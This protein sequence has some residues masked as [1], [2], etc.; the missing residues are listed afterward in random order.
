MPEKTQTERITL[1]DL[2]K[3][4]GKLKGE[5]RAWKDNV[6][7]SG[8]LPLLIAMA[9]LLALVVL[10]CP[11]CLVGV[12]AIGTA[13]AF[14]AP[15]CIV[16]TLI[17]IVITTV[18]LKASNLLK[19]KGVALRYQATSITFVLFGVVVVLYWVLGLV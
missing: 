17:G 9:S 10:G 5:R 16:S 3:R 7:E 2:L 6:E 4:E 11:I 18:A 13:T 12:C 14:H 8:V 1:L 19:H 15:I